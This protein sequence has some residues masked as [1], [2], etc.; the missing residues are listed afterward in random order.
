MATA[1]DKIA[2]CDTGDGGILAEFADVLTDPPKMR[3]KCNTCKYVI[4]P[5]LNFH[6][7]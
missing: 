6:C 5:K 7:N 4:V 1:D 2:P 3:E